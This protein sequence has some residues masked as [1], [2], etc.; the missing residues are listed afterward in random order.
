[1]EVFV[2]LGLTI[3][4][5]LAAAIGAGIGTRFGALGSRVSAALAARFS[6]R[7][8]GRE[9][10]AR[11]A[12]AVFVALAAG[13]ALVFGYLSV[14]RHVSLHTGGYDLG[15]FDQIVWNSLHG[16]LFLN[17]ISIDAP[18]SISHHFA[19]I[20]LA[21][22]PIYSIWSDP[23]A[24]LVLQTLA[25]T[26]AAFPLYWYAR[27]Q[28][29]PGLSLAVA[30]AFFLSPALESVNLWEFHEI[31]LATPLLSFALFFVLRRRYGPFL[32]CMGLALLCKEEVAFILVAFG[33]FILFV[34]RKVKL[35]ALL[36]VLGV[37][38]AAAL[39]LYIIPSFGNVTYG[40]TFEDTTRYTYLGQTVPLIVKTAILQPGLVLQHLLVPAKEEF[41]L[42]LLVPLA[43]IPLFGFE[44]FAISLPVFGY[45]LIGD[46]QFQNSIRYQYTAPLLPMLFF[47]TV[48][49]LKR[50]ARWSR[51]PGLT[52]DLT[53]HAARVAAVGA[54]V[55]TACT[56]DYVFQSAGPL[57]M[58]FEPD[59]YAYTAHTALGYEFM[60]MVPPD[61]SVLADAGFVPH[62]AHR[63]NINEALIAY[64][65]D[66]RKATYLLVDQTLPVHTQFPIIWQDIL[67]SPQFETVAEQDGYL[68]KKVSS[69]PP[70]YPVQIVYGSRISLLGYTIQSP[71]PAERGSTVHV[72]LTWRANT[73]IHDR[74][75]MFVHLLDAKGRLWAQDVREPAN[76][77]FRTDKWKAGDVTKDIY[78][79]ALPADMPP[80]DYSLTAGLFNI[81]TNQRLNAV[82]SAG[83]P[84]ESEPVV[85]VLRVG[86]AVAPGANRTAHPQHAVEATL[87]DLSLL[88]YTAAPDTGTAGASV[89][90][91][92][93]WHAADK[94]QGDWT[95]Q[96]QLRNSAGE[97]QVEQSSRPADNSYPTSAWNVGETVLDWHNLSLPADLGVGEY[98]VFVLL[99]DASSGAVAGQASLGTLNVQN[100]PHQ[101]T[102][103]TVEHPLQVQFGGLIELLGYDA[104]VTPKTAQ[105][106]LYWKSNGPSDKSYTVFVHLLD[107]TNRVVAQQDGIPAG[108]SRPTTGW[109]AGEYIVGN[110][111]LGMPAQASPGGYQLE[112]GLYD[113]ETGARLETA[114]GQDRVLIGDLR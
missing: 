59:Q 64:T 18:I 82:D 17:S 71:V 84:L 98:Q 54:L 56:V 74:Y 91:G 41:V 31:A 93:F 10:H 87:G 58:H 35:G 99:S 94:P 32:V 1:M 77:W 85:G 76:G 89:D 16:R 95:V 78:T 107:S 23:L 48:L 73:A 45:L 90:Y 92:L 24:L 20:L 102:A 113:A 104:V 25:L 26:L 49:G 114:D 3:P 62:M 101:F 37:V 2:E 34:Q 5:A 111:T 46:N 38:W 72:V 108:G 88:G 42:Q 110:Y 19:P 15:I 27:A 30:L 70:A 36:A 106:T 22:V 11:V 105:I 109:V 83:K 12:D 66:L 8:R 60:S 4:I 68:L 33:L 67:A 9:F 80:G 40:H 100:V 55:A 97:V 7:V 103:P 29:G 61:A 81:A 47:A 53:A 13:Y 57:G 50:L 96:V 112:I 51:P 75:D 6:V 63:T 44:V 39:L 28:I 43:C 79:L 21:L 69:R 14:M 86:Q 65:P 52:R